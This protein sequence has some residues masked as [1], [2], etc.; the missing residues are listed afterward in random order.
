M[1]AIKHI[2]WHL[3][4]MAAL[5]TLVFLLLY[6]TIFV[7]YYALVAN[8]GQEESVIDQFA[9]LTGAPFVFCTAPFVVYL[10]TR[11]L[12]RKAGGYFYSHALLYVFFFWLIDFLTFVTQPGGFERWF[13]FPWALTLILNS[14]IMLL[15][16][17]LGAYLAQKNDMHIAESSV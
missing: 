12:C 7:T 8:P 15:A 2:K 4:L 11:W 6:L 13:S 16:A 17:L 10:T 9:Q 1:N 3:L 5:G 14:A